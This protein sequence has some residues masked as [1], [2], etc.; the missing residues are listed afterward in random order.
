MLQMRKNKLYKK[1]NIVHVKKFFGTE[2]FWGPLRNA[3]QESVSGPSIIFQ[4]G[5]LSISSSYTCKLAK[6]VS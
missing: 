2:M 6:H 5:F 3:C 1:M 4:I